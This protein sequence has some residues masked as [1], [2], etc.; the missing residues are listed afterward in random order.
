MAYTAR[1]EGDELGRCIYRGQREDTGRK[2]ARTTASGCVVLE[3]P[4]KV[5]SYA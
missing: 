2:G 4:A 3:K 1:S 5:S